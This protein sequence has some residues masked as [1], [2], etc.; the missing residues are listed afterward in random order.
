MNQ[1]GQGIIY[2]FGAK[3]AVAILALLNAILIPRILGPESMGFYTY[4]LSVYFILGTILSLGGSSIIFRYIPE[5]RKNDPKSVRPLLKKVLWIKI[6]V[7]ILIFFAGQFVKE[8]AYF[9]LILLG[10]AIFS[11]GLIVRGILY[12]YKQMGKYSFFQPAGMLSKLILILIL[13]S[14]W[15]NTG[16]LLAIIL[17]S[18][19]ITPIFG[20][21]A[22]KALPKTSG[23]LSRPFKEI[24]GFG[25]LLYLGALLS[26]LTHWLLP[27][28]LKRYIEDLAAIGYLG[29]GIQVYLLIINFVSSIGEGV[30]PSLIE[31]YTEADERFTRSIQLTWRYANLILLPAASG[32]FILVEPAIITLVGEKFLPSAKIIKLLLPASIFASWTYIHEQILFSFKKKSQMF[33]VQLIEFATCLGTSLYLIKNYGLI[34]APVSLSLAALVGFVLS[35]FFSWKL[36]PIPEYLSSFFKPFLASCGMGLIIEFLPATNLLSLVGAILSGIM[37]YLIIMVAIRGITKEDLKRVTRIF[38][39]KQE[40]IIYR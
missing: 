1:I 14:F 35:L 11:L 24:L 31:F 28:V 4:W 34:G 33:F 20:L 29:L 19:L 36:K 21:P 37:I 7:V 16:I 17:S 25:L 39:A 38:L 15:Q 6:P 5:F 2:I 30:L 9:L 13:F 10:A 23:S 27:V 12:A 32:I 18:I 40:K 8:K 26:T 3:V 22:V